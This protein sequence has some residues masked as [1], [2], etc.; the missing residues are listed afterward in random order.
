MNSK[1]Y[2][3]IQKEIFFENIK[4]WVCYELKEHINAYLENDIL[5]LDKNF[6]NELLTCEYWGTAE[7]IAN[8]YII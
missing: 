3:K 8:R 1:E 6:I 7:D 5:K 4:E 2:I